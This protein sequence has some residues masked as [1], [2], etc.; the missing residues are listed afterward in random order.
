MCGVG[1]VGRTK[2]LGRYGSVGCHVPGEPRQ[3]GS[4]SF[5]FSDPG[6]DLHNV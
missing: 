2:A 1:D 4:H 5:R 3:A 6:Y